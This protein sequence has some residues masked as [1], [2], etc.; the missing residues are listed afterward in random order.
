[1]VKFGVLVLAG[2]VVVLGLLV[3]GPSGTGA[4]APPTPGA[5]YHEQ[6]PADGPLALE[7]SVEVV[8][9][10]SPFAGGSDVGR[11]TV[12]VRG[13]LTWDGQPLDRGLVSA[14]CGAVP[15]QAFANR[16]APGAGDDVLVTSHPSAP[17][18]VVYYLWATYQGRTVFLTRALPLY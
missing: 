4:Q 10:R 6:V 16:C 1:M 15:A 8:P 7:A 2:G 14:Y 18:T 13:R 17:G 11:A 5:T 12:V 3:R 9:V